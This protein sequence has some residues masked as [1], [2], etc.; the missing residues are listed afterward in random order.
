MQNLQLPPT[1]PEEMSGGEEEL[2]TAQPHS[3][4]DPSTPLP[5]WTVRLRRSAPDE[6]TSVPVTR[7]THTPSAGG[8][9][10]R[11]CPNGEFVPDL[12][13]SAMRGMLL[14]QSGMDDLVDTERNKVMEARHEALNKL[15]Q[16]RE[17]VKAEKERLKYVERKLVEN[18]DSHNRVIAEFESARNVLSAAKLEEAETDNVQPKREAK[19]VLR[20]CENL[21][22]SLENSIAVSATRLAGWDF[23]NRRQTALIERLSEELSK[24]QDRYFIAC[25]V[26]IGRLDHLQ[27]LK[28]L[29]A[30]IE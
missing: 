17:R 10:S 7:P 21:C 11:L 25:N 8:F 4:T 30:Q 15:R 16:S 26:F 9:L 29:L 20:I 24:E 23:K 13:C 12:L 1:D 22:K 5:T 28:D 19:A 6:A 2:L 27:A 18:R 3:L 14:V